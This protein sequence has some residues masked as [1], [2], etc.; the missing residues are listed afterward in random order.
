MDARNKGIWINIASIAL[1]S[2]APVINK[3]A[4]GY[5]GPVQAAFF[6]T[7]F[8]LAMTWIW[9]KS[10]GG[11]VRLRNKI[12]WLV[13]LLDGV[14]AILVYTALSLISPVMVGFLERFYV[15]IALLLAITFLREKITPRQLLLTGVAILGLWLFVDKQ[16]DFSSILGIAV[17]IIYTS[18]FALSA[19]LV[20]IVSPMENTR[21]ILLSEK[22]VSLI[23]IGLYW[24]VAENASL[25]GVTLTGMGIVL[26]CAGLVNFLGVMLFY[27]GLRDV[28]FN[29]VNLI[30][31]VSPVLVFAYSWFVYPEKLDA[32]KIIGAVVLLGAVTL[33]TLQS[34]REEART[35]T[36]TVNASSE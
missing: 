19:M 6:N 14:A 10:Q 12:L 21:D 2:L 34:S 30:R 29:T 31:S 24:V 26:V 23:V 7:L 15:I 28:T 5:I 32:S 20:K 3:F 4:V 13:G 1:M 25:A 8:S 33:L 18:F 9:V 11:K 16:F 17:T 27:A 35:V 22:I 36:Q